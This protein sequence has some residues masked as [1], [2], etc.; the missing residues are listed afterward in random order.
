MHTNQAAK[1][2]VIKNYLLGETLFER[3]IFLFLIGTE[4]LMSFSFLGFIHIPPISLTIAYFPIIVSGVLLK[5]PQTLIISLIFGLA[6]LFKAT[7]N[8]VMPS[9]AIFSPFS[10]NAPF[11][12]IFLSL[13]TRLLFGAIIAFLFSLAKNKKFEYLRIGIIAAL[14]PKIHS[15]LVLTALGIFF[16]EFNLNSADTLNWD[17]NTPI[18]ALASIACCTGLWYLLNTEKMQFIGYTINHASK[19]P[20]KSKI[21]FFVLIFFVLLLIGLSIAAAVY[22]IDR[23]SYM[24]AQY[25]IIIT[26]V[27]SA[28]LLFLQCQFAFA[29]IGIMLLSITVLFS[30]YHY[31][32]YKEYKGGMDAITKVMSRKMFFYYCHKIENKC[33]TKQKNTPKWFLFVDIDFFKV[34]NDS[35]GRATGDKIL[36]EIAQS[37]SRT[38]KDIGYTGRIGGDEFAVIIEKPISEEELETRLSKFLTHI[39]S[40]LTEIEVSCSIGGYEFLFPQKLSNILSMADAMLYKA[41]EGGKSCYRLQPLQSRDFPQ[42]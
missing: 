35:F 21:L 30:F 4:L 27:I 10:S 41:K 8:Y 7:P 31:M 36:Y 1:N 22:F 9:D 37:L 29:M 42:E 23:Y 24:L 33:K 25:G 5:M 38:F 20:Y 18:T 16:P 34:I 6:T 40:L 19:N 17:S 3:Y 11:C 15:L 32:S 26:P 14:A 2:S 12:S 13:C 28:D 39:A